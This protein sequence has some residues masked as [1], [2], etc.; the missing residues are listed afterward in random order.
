MKPS[1]PRAVATAARTA[2]ASERKKAVDA[3]AATA[4]KERTAAGFTRGA[5]STIASTDHSM[6]L[7]GNQRHSRA[8]ISVH[9]MALVVPRL[10]LA[11]SALEGTQGIS[12]GEGC[13]AGRN[14]CDVVT[15][16]RQG[17]VWPGVEQ[18]R[19]H[20]S[21]QWSQLGRVASQACIRKE[22]P[23]CCQW[24]RRSEACDAKI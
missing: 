19:S 8:L 18:Q 6:A 22:Q 15:G 12:A 10:D 23:Q 7:G 9:S 21:H 11:V 13:D 2:R 16:R 5:G 14:R 1:E 3:K 17:V 20:Q 24:V 4:A